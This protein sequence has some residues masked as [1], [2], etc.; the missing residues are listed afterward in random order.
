MFTV[1]L[2]AALA[3]VI[4]T[5]ELVTLQLSTIRHASDVLAPPKLPT[6]GIGATIPAL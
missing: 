4:W 1:G 2:L 6:L 3:Y 5:C